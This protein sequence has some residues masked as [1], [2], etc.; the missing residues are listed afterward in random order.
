MRKWLLQC[1]T[2]DRA[3]SRKDVGSRRMISSAV[4]LKNHLESFRVCAQKILGIEKS[5][6]FQWGSGLLRIDPLCL[7]TYS[8]LLTSTG[9]QRH[10]PLSGGVSRGGFSEGLSWQIFGFCFPRYWVGPEKRQPWH[11]SKSAGLGTR[12]EGSVCGGELVKGLTAF[13]K[14]IN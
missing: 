8:D 11:N 4:V 7:A 6:L 2:S 1:T 13:L 5:A 9:A 12:R 10:P 14:A 3:E